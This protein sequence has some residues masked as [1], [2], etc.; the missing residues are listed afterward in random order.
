MMLQV[1]HAPH[2]GGDVPE[3]PVPPRLAGCCVIT[4][5]MVL[6]IALLGIHRSWWLL[7]SWALMGE[8]VFRNCSS[9]QTEWVWF[10]IINYVW[11]DVPNDS[12]LFLGTDSRV[13]PWNVYFLL[14]AFKC[15]ERIVSW[16]PTERFCENTH[17]IVWFFLFLYFISWNWNGCAGSH[18]R[19]V[20]KC[21]AGLAGEECWKVHFLVNQSQVFWWC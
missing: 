14:E 9:S 3:H 2:W 15:Q 19:Q 17:I 13:L 5:A 11:I 6:D 10:Y 20:K 21:L 12:M 8:T 18:L 1:L 16:D 4:A 7:S